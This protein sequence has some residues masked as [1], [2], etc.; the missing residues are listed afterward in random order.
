MAITSL[1]HY[2]SIEASHKTHTTTLPSQAAIQ[3]ASSSLPSPSSPTYLAS[4]PAETTIS[5]ITND[6]LPALTGQ[7]RSGRYF[8]FVTGGVQ[9]IAEWADNIVSHVD[10]NVQVHLPNQTVAT[11]VEDAALSMLA[12][13]LK[14]EEGEWKGRTFTTGATA[15]N[16]LGLACGRETIINK[17]IADG[18]G[19]VGDL[20]LLKACRLADIDEIQ[21]LTSAGHSSLSKAASIVGLGRDSVLQLPVSAEEPWKLDFTA[22]EEHIR[23]PRVASIIAVSLG[24]VN[25]GRFAVQGLED[26]K[27]LRALA[28]EHGAWIH[29]DGG[30][31]SR[32][33][34]EGS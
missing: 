11:N 24:E 20:G 19:T 6:I 18:K 33:T 29:V 2:L 25:T 21:V 9:P 23:K 30:M 16:V 13:V 7:S 3:T 8:G 15:S 31:C 34:V 5:H 14:L 10:Q 32:Q 22:V 1:D 27:R 26:M 4:Q 12:G 17:R 28:D